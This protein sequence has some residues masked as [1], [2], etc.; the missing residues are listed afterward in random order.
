MR[1]R[2]FRQPTPR[3]T[4]RSGFVATSVLSV[5]AIGA[6]AVSACGGGEGKS[7]KTPDGAIGVTSTPRAEVTIRPTEIPT[8]IPTATAVKTEILSP[9]DLI[10]AGGNVSGLFAEGFEGLDVS[11]ISYSDI[12]QP[13]ERD[14]QSI[15]N[16]ISI[17]TGA[18]PYPYRDDAEKQRMD[19]DVTFLATG[20]SGFCELAG[21]ASSR[22]Y[23][24]TGREQFKQANMLMEKI[25]NSVVVD[26][27]KK[28][29][30]IKDALW[31]SLKSRFYPFGAT[32]TSN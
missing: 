2:D 24:A 12:P 5:M 28:D 20:V 14:L 16:A 32:G 29:P 8:I 30:R 3:N 10:S 7:A 15:Q 26:F 22:L 1:D 23:T 11:A 25:H 17:C 13:A 19:Q 31:Q 9:Q 6:V 4:R 18:V 21:E 27:Q